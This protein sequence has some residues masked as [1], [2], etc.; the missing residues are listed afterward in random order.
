[1]GE[2]FALIVRISQYQRI[3]LALVA[4]LVA[5]LIPTR[6]DNFLGIEKMNDNTKN[7][8]AAKTGTSYPY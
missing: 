3:Y 4:A 2:L 6:D 5:A 7:C 1:M 8:T